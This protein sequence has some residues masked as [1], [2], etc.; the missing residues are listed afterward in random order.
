MRVLPSLLLC[1]LPILI[2]SA[3]I[4]LAATDPLAASLRPEERGFPSIRSFI[5]RDYQGH[6]Q[7]WTAVEGNNEVMFFGANDEII[8]FDGI[9]WR[10]IPIP[11]GSFIRAMDVDAA[12]TIWVGGVNELGYIAPAPG[13]EI[14][15]HSLLS[16][17]PPEI[18]Q[19]GDVR[20]AIVMPDGVYF[21]TDAYLFRWHQE[22]F[23]L[24]PMHEPYV[25]L[26][27]R[28][29]DRIIVSRD[30]S[31]A[32]PTADGG[33][34]DLPG[35]PDPDLHLLL[36]HIVPTGDG[37]WWA[38]V[39]AG[40]L[41]RYDGKSTTLLD[42]T[43]ADYLRRSRLFG[44]SRMQD[45]RLLFPSLGRGLL[46]TDAELRP[47]AHL[48]ANS[49]LPSSTIICVT[50]TRDGIVWVGTER[51]IARLDLT[52]GITRFTPLNGLE[53][54][55]ANT[56]LRLNDQP[57]FATSIGPLQLSAGP[58]TTSNP[59]FTTPIQ[60][61]DKL[62][63]FHPM[64]DGLLV[65][66]LRSLWWVDAQNEITD[67]NSP[68]NISSILLHPRF[69]DHAFALHLTGLAVWRRKGAGWS[70]YHA[71]PA[72][73]GELQS[74]ALDA[75]GDIWIGSPNAGVWRL[76]YGS[77]PV[78]GPG[79]TLVDPTPVHYGAEA[80]LPAGRNRINVRSIGGR[81]LF[82]TSNGLYR[83]DSET[84]KF[85]P[86]TRFDPRFA[87]GTWAA[88]YVT[89]SPRGGLWL[90]ARFTWPRP[91]G[92]FRQFGKVVDGQW[93]PLHLANLEEIGDIDDLVCEIVNDQEILWIC[94]K[95]GV[96]RVNASQALAS[97]LPTIGPTV[98][99]HVT[100]SS[101][102][103]LVPATTNKSP[104]EISPTENSLRF[105][106][107]TPGL[108][109]EPDAQ[110]VSRLIGFV[111]G[112]AETS[113]SGERTF[114]N[115]PPG[116]YTFEVSGRTAD[117]HWSS[118]AR[119]E[120]LV[121]TAWWATWWAKIIYGLIAA[122]AVYLIVR[123][124]TR[125]LEHQREELEQIVAQRT[126]EL[127]KKA[128]DLERLHQL[129]QDAT[130]TARL[131]AETTRLELLRYQLNPH[132]LFNS[133]NSIRALV[134]S[135]PETA[136]E[137]VSKLAEFCRRTLSRSGDEMVSVADEMEM[138]RNYLEI[139][140]VRWQEG[141][142]VTVDISPASLTCQL[143]QNLLLP[144][145]ENAIKYG[146]R[147]SPGILEV[148]IK[149]TH[150]NNTL[151]CI[152]ANSGRWISASANPFGDS[153]HIGLQNLRQ[154]LRRHYGDVARMSHD[155]DESHVTVRLTFPCFP[156]A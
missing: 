30:Q 6:N 18:K 145:L 95:G 31:W 16:F 92:S 55:G 75:Q 85:T 88:L 90:E 81:P 24:W 34:E 71:V 40:G 130:L 151:T 50:P 83:F 67:L 144:L 131:A 147:T 119:V 27:T 68:S 3:G 13:G 69:P 73:L 102:L 86:D 118:P 74:M 12:G 135:A 117:H 155:S 154:R 57:I 64:P 153:T 54:S 120:L 47:L 59:I 140:Q 11:G 122:I 101:G 124:R 146:G 70:E 8:T 96:I 91:K 46:I 17:L 152:V 44:V 82:L 100:T 49:G 39:G 107:G 114:T 105:R 43:V 10:K 128:K 25:T 52:A 60:I 143:P 156:P 141:L 113:N 28:W 14:T 9:T 48:D 148:S 22:A 65:G 45:G 150:E 37:E 103:K 32:M 41:A 20:R 42:G 78:P 58:T 26:A 142:V 62:N 19:V 116:R 108:A 5:P 94:G 63:A 139:E 66:G 111:D 2:G 149:I 61:D 126:R 98:L 112:S 121:L 89:E 7:I 93:N 35:M 136:G 80:G 56:V 84:E 137:M 1:W 129:E 36:S 125:R 79:D 76:P 132:F 110:H 21:Q 99:H 53:R 4:S 97:A 115:L 23:Q 106:F 104:L 138:A 133:L 38:S 87:D 29:Q 127:A 33:W 123:W 109:G 51:G 134:Y 72:P 77:V 15:F